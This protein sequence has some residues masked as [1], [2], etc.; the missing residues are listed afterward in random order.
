M[1]AEMNSEFHRAQICMEKT[2]EWTVVLGKA[3][4]PLEGLL[5]SAQ[6]RVFGMLFGKSCEVIVE[7]RWENWRKTFLDKGS[8]NRGP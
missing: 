7:V 6:A 5:I 3:G 2:R 1:G 4:G 8:V